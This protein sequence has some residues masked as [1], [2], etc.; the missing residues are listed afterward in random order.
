MNAA[1]LIGFGVV[2]LLVC[3]I[4]SG[5]LALL[6]PRLGR[7]GPAVE[8]RIAELAAW[9]PV[10]VAGAVV[11]ILVIQSVVG[12]DHCDTHGHHAHLCLQHGMAWAERPGAIAIV[13]AGIAIVAARAVVVVASNVRGH[14]N[15]AR[16]RQTL[17]DDARVQLVTSDRVFCF[18]AGLRRPAI[19]VSTAARDAL[20]RDEWDAMLAHETSHVTHRD[21]LH[22]LGLEL[23]LLFAAPLAGI[24][25][26]ERWDAATERLRDADAAEHA[27]PE[28]VASALVHMARAQ[29]LPRLGPIAAFTATD[30]RLLTSRVQSLLDGTP[31]G[32]SSARQ[33]ARVAV[34][35]TLVV[36]MLALVFAEPLHHAL[37]TLLG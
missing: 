37:E 10:V 15:V 5:V 26:R 16:L 12:F 11:T 24:T 36:M 30:A 35:S 2:F 27:S 4:T 3:G 19:Y 32:E 9:V 31:R 28:A 8:R 33:L 25:I 29:A 18:V 14:V 1:S 34:A 17:S 6:V 13:A 7:R 23:L 21:L 20:A 22:R